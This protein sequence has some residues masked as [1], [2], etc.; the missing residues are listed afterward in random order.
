M[1]FEYLAIISGGRGPDVWDKEITVSGENMTIS[2]ALEQIE[3][4]IVDEDAA[5]VSIEQVD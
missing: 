4:Q 1:F 3:S 2:Q 5:V